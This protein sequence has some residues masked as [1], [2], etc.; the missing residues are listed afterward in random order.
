M[1]LMLLPVIG[2]LLLAS[3]GGAGTPETR[4]PMTSSNLLQ[5]TNGSN[6][7]YSVAGTYTSSAS[8]STPEKVTGRVFEVF[9]RDGTSYQI[10]ATT[11][12]SLQRTSTF[13][14]ASGGQSSGV[15]RLAQEVDGPV[16]LV[17]DDENF[18]VPQDVANSRGLP[19]V[20]PG[21]FVVGNSFDT[22]TYRLFTEA[23]DDYKD[24]RG[25]CTVLSREDVKTD[26]GIF[27]AYK[28]NCRVVTQR[29]VGGGYPLGTFTVDQTIWVHTGVGIIKIT[30]S[31]TLEFAGSD[32]FDYTQTLTGTSVRLVPG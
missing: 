24:Y 23:N 16:G 32:R 27:D 19:I 1:R 12:A 7:D 8:G 18:Y 2:A 10:G 9:S 20:L 6:F 14:D 31:E 13:N 3:C 15:E 22:G 11:Q 17:M 4:Y 28:V 29:F 5:I 26:I 30:G 25:G 21:I